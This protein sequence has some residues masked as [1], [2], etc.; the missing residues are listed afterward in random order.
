MLGA[1]ALAC[2]GVSGATAG[3]AAA[4]QPNC[5]ITSAAPYSSRY[6]GYQVYPASYSWC[7]SGTSP[8]IRVMQLYSI[9]QFYSGGTWY[10]APYGYSQGAGAGTVYAVHGSST[11]TCQ[12]SAYFREA[13]YLAV[14]MTDGSVHAYPSASTWQFGPLL[15][16]ALASGTCQT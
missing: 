3:T 2:L 16:T 5:H 6:T 13:D 9:V 12:G 1:V 15:N 7:G 11:W 4:A 8:G 14:T 10:N